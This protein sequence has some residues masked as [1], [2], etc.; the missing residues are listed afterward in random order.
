MPEQ[1]LSEMF[2]YVIHEDSEVH[3]DTCGDDCFTVY[4][5]FYHQLN[6]DGSKSDR[7]MTTD[8]DGFDYIRRMSKDFKCLGNDTYQLTLDKPLESVV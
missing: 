2:Y 8:Q 1:H 7:L 3:G 4:Q 6:A 5:Y